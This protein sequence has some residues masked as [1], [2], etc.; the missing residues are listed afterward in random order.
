MNEKEV[1]EILR[2]MMILGYKPKYIC[3]YCEVQK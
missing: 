2:N 3:R 1:K